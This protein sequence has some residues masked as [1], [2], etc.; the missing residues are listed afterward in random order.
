MSDSTDSLLSTS[1][2]WGCFFFSCS[3]QRCIQ[4]L[5]KHFEKNVFIFLLTSFFL[6]F[7]QIKS[8]MSSAKLWSSWEV[9]ECSFLHS[10]S[11]TVCGVPVLSIATVPVLWLIVV[12]LWSISTVLWTLLFYS[13]HE[14]VGF[15]SQVSFPLLWWGYHLFFLLLLFWHQLPS[16]DECHFNHDVLKINSLHW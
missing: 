13:F 7:L 16:S 8:A 4:T 2:Y 14:F 12:V 10:V 3:N 5:A 1:V 15:H 11:V 9:S 6:P